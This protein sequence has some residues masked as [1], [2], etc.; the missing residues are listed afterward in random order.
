MNIEFLTS[1]WETEYEQFLLK[2]EHT[3]FYHSNG[4]R[5]FLKHLIQV[6]DH[7]LI[8]VENGE[9]VGAL[10]S[11]LCKGKTGTS[12]NS[13]VFFGSNGGVIEFNG[14]RQVRNALVNGFYELGENK[15][16]L[17]AT[18]ISSPFDTNADCYL[19]YDYLDKRIGQ[20]TS[21]RDL[22]HNKEKNEIYSFGSFTRRM[23]RKAIKNSVEAK[24]ENDDDSF[25]FLENTHYENMDEIGGKKKPPAFFSAVRNHFKAGHDYNLW[26]A[27]R[28]SRPIAGMLLFYYNHTVEYYIPAIL[29]DYK[30]IQPTSLLIFEAMKDAAEKG[31]H[32]WN[33]GGTHLDQEGVHRFKKQWNTENIPY[34]Y[35]IRV[36][37]DRLF[38]FTEQTIKE[39]FPYCY[40]IPYH[41]LRD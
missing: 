4:F 36:Y 12:L 19:G 29:K 28:H 15:G 33:W 38:S 34:H 37:D 3:L 5:K 14:N 27:Y 7:Y 40:L 25:H 31:Y 35:Y 6:D 10:P 13:L 24:I 21:L 2:G 8:A 17:S 41:K 30:S 9:I 16:C 22:S 20:I 11:V 1:E 26:M 23:I 32:Y 39:E 18:L